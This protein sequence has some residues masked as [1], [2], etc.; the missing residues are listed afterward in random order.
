MEDMKKL[1]GKKDKNVDPMKK[2]AKLSALKG[3][4]S[5]MSSMMQD[6]LKGKMNKVTVAAPD[7]EHLKEGLDKAKEIVEEVPGDEHEAEDQ[8]QEDTPEIAAAEQ[9][10]EAV[11]PKMNAEEIDAMIKMLSEMKQN[12][13]SKE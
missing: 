4:K 7:K 6:G 11:A 1:L 8:E 13:P 12:L 9:A 5:E 3:L 10:M 2:E